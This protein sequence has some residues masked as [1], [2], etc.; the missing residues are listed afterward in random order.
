MSISPQSGG[1]QEGAGPTPRKRL[2]ESSQCASG[3]RAGSALF[4]R[5]FVG[6]SDIYVLQA[7]VETTRVQFSAP[8]DKTK[9]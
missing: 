7:C 3:V 2:A 4:L 5:F 8:K 1:F 9:Q 6:E